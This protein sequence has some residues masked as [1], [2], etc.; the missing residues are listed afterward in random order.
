MVVII[1]GLGDRPSIELNRMTPLQAATTPALDRLASEGQCGLVDPLMPGMPVE[2]HTGV[3]I[4]LGMTPADGV[5]LS[6]G[7]VEAAGIGLN[8]KY[9]DVLMRANLATIE[10]VDYGFRIVDRRAGRITEDTTE[11]CDSCMNVD[12]GDGISAKLFPAT[13][14]RVVLRLR[15]Q[16][17]SEQISDTDPGSRHVERGVLRSR[18]MNPSDPASEFTAQLL[19][20]FT[21]LAVERLSEHP[22]NKERKKAGKLPVTGVIC[23][24]AG[25]YKSTTNILTSL[26]L[27]VAVVAGEKTIVGL[28]R[29]FDFDT[30]SD[31][32]FTSLPDTDVDAKFEKALELLKEKDLVYVHIKGTDIVSHDCNPELKKVFIERIDQAISRLQLEDILIGICA[33]HSS[34]STRGVHS[35][36]PVPVI[37]RDPDGRRDRVQHF[38]EFDCSEGSLQR[39]TGQG[40]LTCLLDAMGVLRNFKP[41]YTDIFSFN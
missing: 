19:N 28:G 21:S 33:D 12:L 1:D 11:F 35:G 2:T 34:D 15:G 8:M 41:S 20:R 6:R 5:V 7:P 32:S 31:P 13:H 3:G 27:N 40:W 37:L 17:L 18:P 39:L 4:L 36:D 14:H 9:G 24:G 10:P 38:N 29:M 30:I 26:G 16:G 23:R 22:T 25:V